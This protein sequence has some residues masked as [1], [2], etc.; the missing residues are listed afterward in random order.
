MTEF[1]V[2]KRCTK[3]FEQISSITVISATTSDNDQSRRWGK[4]QTARCR[5]QYDSS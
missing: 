2:D 1:V 4:R 5:S 3:N